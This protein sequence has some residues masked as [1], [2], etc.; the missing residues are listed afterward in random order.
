[1]GLADFLYRCPRCGHDPMARKGSRVAC[2]SCGAVF[3]PSTGGRILIE[4]ADRSPAL[5]PAKELGRILDSLG[6]PLTAATDAQGRIRYGTM[7]LASAGVGMEPVRL[8]GEVVGFIEA[9]GS[10]QRGRLEATDRELS[11]RAEAAAESAVTPLD[12]IRCIQTS[13]SSLQVGIDRGLSQFRFEVDSPRRWETL[14]RELIRREYRRQGRGEIL[15]FQPRI[16]TA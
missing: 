13:S 4:Q 6:G 15:E 5:V 12:S 9:L 16:V 1:M 11:F 7:V 8:G 14:L 3:S 2:P 10:A